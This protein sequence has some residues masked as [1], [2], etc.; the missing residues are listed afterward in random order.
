[1]GVSSYFEFVTTLFGW[2]MYD[3]LWGVITGA[4]LVSIPFIVVILSN[5]TSSKKAGDDEG[6]AGVQ[7]LKKTEVDV[8]FMVGVIFL[9]AV[10]FSTVTLSEMHYA[11]PAYDCS[12]ADQIA[13]GAPATV[14]GSATGTTYDATLQTLSGEVG[15]IPVWW[16]AMHVLTKAVVAASI[17]GIPCTGDLAAVNM[18]LENDSLTDPRVGKEVQEFIGDCY[19][20]AKSQFIRKDQ[21]ALSPEER[22]SINHMG[23]S[24][25]INT[26]G[27]Y[28][29]YYSRKPRSDWAFDPV[30]DGGYEQHAPAGHPTCKEWWEDAGSGIRAKVLNAVEP[31]II[32][33]HVYSPSNLVQQSTRNNLNVT[34]REDIFLRKVLAVQNSR[35]NISGYTND[36]SVSYA[37]KHNFNG[38]QNIASTT[39]DL[40]ME[41]LS[42][43]AASVGMVAS[44]PSNL[45][46]GVVMREG[47]SIFVSIILMMFVVV[48]P[49]LMLFSLYKVSTLLTL[50]LVFF[51]L[52]FFY[53]L[54]AVAFWVDNSLIA[55]IMSSP[56]GSGIFTAV[57]NPVQTSIIVWSQRILYVAFPVIWMSSLTWVG[58]RAANAL[59]NSMSNMTGEMAASGEKG[60]EMV[61]SAVTKGKK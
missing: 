39:G 17:A 48:L 21:S 47:V 37:P 55:A 11:R 14:N 13:G 2:V 43:A 51:S 40:I 60:G 7:S 20:P 24:Y 18:R 1:M 35:A 4:G 57:A 46:G 58:I 15:R 19:M 9:A 54:W 31:D 25:F 3:Q 53:F 8:V 12:I 59:S 61:S 33:E 52:H 41:G 23:S 38:T 6:S 29:K 50:T 32:D 10:P 44:A 34:D 45:A 49:F 16:A 36:L 30:R 28:D 42:T 26:P 5:I 22:E 56:N 27:Y